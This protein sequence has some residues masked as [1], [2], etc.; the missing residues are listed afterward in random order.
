MSKQTPFFADNSFLDKVAVAEQH[1]FWK[2]SEIHAASYSL[3]Q[4]IKAHTTIINMCESYLG[5]LVTWMAGVRCGTLQVLPASKNTIDLN[6]DLINKEQSIV[7]VDSGLLLSDWE[8]WNTILVD[9]E[10][11]SVSLAT[12]ESR[13]L[14]DCWSTARICLYTSG[15]TGMPQAVFKTMPELLKGAQLLGARISQEINFSLR[16]VSY[17]ISS[18]APRHMYGVETVLMLSLVH[19]VAVVDACPLLPA[20]IEYAFRNRKGKSLWVSTPLHMRALARVGVKLV[21]C[22]GVVSSTM[23]LDHQ[24]ARYIEVNCQATVMEIYGS[25]ETGVVATRRTTESNEWELLPGVKITPSETEVMVTASHNIGINIL[26]D[27]IQMKTPTRFQLLG[28]CS[29]LIKVGGKRASLAG[30]NQ[31]LQ[32][33]LDVEQSVLYMPMTNTENQRPVLIYVGKRLYSQ[34]LKRRLIDKIPSVFVPR[35][36]IQVEKIPVSA[37]G[38]PLYLELEQLYKLWVSGDRG[39]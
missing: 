26:N 35:V 23:P 28:R 9:S 38:K 15:S 31:I 20:D 3:A 14:P 29:D 4:K 25:T 8:G 21:S 13:K 2:W 1:K 16:Q 39:Q 11:L 12:G 17:I 5:L 19:G 7:V 6:S 24:V 30:L 34:E 27:M 18:V 36:L 10:S 22:A 33:E 37:S 32:S